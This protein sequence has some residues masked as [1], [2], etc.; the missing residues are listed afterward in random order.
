LKKYF[1]WVYRLPKDQ[2]AEITAHLKVK[3]PKTILRRDQIPTVEDINGM[4]GVSQD[5]MEQVLVAFLF[6]SAARINEVL[7]V[8]VE[9]VKEVE[10]GL[11]VPVYETKAKTDFREIPCVFSAQYIRNLI[12]AHRLK[13]KDR[14]FPIVDVTA[15][16]I[17]KK[18]AKAAGV[19]KRMCAHMFRHAGII[20]MSL[21]EYPEAIIK[22][23]VGHSPDSKM[24]ARYQHIIGSDVIDYT[25]G[26][27][28]HEQPKELITPEDL[29]AKN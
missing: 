11:I 7:P 20:D 28:N 29:A 3:M 24:L 14:L 12:Q 15:W 21:R 16:R 2:D 17:I 8:L 18:L 27:T 9:D 6:D 10:G 4:I 23:K 26:K 13:P 25:F 5:L 1:R 22:K 19:E